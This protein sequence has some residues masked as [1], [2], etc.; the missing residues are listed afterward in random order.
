VFAVGCD[1]GS[2]LVISVT[3]VVGL[4]EVVLSSVSS[5]VDP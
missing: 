1:V 2:K 5:V 3:C 4:S